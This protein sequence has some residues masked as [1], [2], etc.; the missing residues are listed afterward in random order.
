MKLPRA[1]LAV[2]LGSAASLVAQALFSLTMLRW[3]TPQAVG[4]FAVL[5]QIAFFWM[6]LALAQSPL[7]LL[8]EAQHTP[9]QALREALVASLRRMLWLAPAVAGA[10]AW[11]HHPSSAEA[12]AWA[13]GLALMQGG[14]YLAQPYALKTRPPH[15]A[16]LAKATPPVT[17]LAL[18]TLAAVARPAA[19]VEALLCAALAGYAVG[20]LWLLPP[21]TV[22]RQE[23]APLPGSVP[24]ARPLSIT[25]RDD[26][27]VRLRL[28]HTAVD[29]LTGAGMLIIWQRAHGAVEA[30]YLAVLLRLLGFVPVLVH[31]SWAQ[32]LLAGATGQPCSPLRAGLLGAVATAA[33]GAACALALH[34]GLAPSWHAALAYIAPLTLWQ[35]A[36]CVHAACSHLPFQQGRATAFSLT[37]IAVAVIQWVLLGLPL[38]WPGSPLEP[39]LHA[40]WLSAAS[41]IALLSWALWMAKMGRQSGQT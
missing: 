31:A 15:S 32:V 34:A 39:A 4:S 38:W 6:T 33:M 1:T 7:T 41:G 24:A 5:S 13:L 2:A 40:W 20:A 10:V 28:A 16:A 8:A 11:S 9:R 36:A 3:F 35:A 22:P 30:G 23:S 18:A 26:R 12:L 29:A 37:A 17:A 19:Q 21:R 27:S 14:W 25:Q